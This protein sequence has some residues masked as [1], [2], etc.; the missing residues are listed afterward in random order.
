MCPQNTNGDQRS[1]AE[2]FTYSRVVL[3]SLSNTGP[4]MH[5]CRMTKLRIPLLDYRFSRRLFAKKIQ[6]HFLKQC[7]TNTNACQV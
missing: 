4:S 7:A 3:N 1:S 6:M 2:S 5:P